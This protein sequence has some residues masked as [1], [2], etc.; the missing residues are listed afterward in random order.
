MGKVYCI[1]S[2]KGGVGK[3]TV[4]ANLSECIAGLN[5]KV[6]VIDMD[7]GLRNLDIIMNLENRILFNIVDVLRSRCRINQAIVTSKHCN[8][9]FLLPTSQTATNADIDA[10]A[11]YSLLMLLRENFDYIIIDSPAGAEIGFL[12]SVRYAD[13]AIVVVQADIAS[14]RDADKIFN[15]LSESGIECNKVIVNKYNHQLE[16]NGYVL[17]VDDISRILGTEEIF[18]IPEDKEILKAN[19]FGRNFL[20]HK[21]KSFYAYKNIAK[22]LI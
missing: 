4:V 2:G 18:C 8:N 19:N 13:E 15:L 20:I 7:T 17:K 12:N 14:I 5:K 3:T 10:C 22:S 11:L 9:L 21:N 1:T 16:R 6:L